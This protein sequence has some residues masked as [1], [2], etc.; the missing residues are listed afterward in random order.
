MNGF[1]SRQR[2]FRAN[3]PFR[4]DYRGNFSI[5]GLALW[6]RHRRYFRCH[7]FRSAGFSSHNIPRR[8]CCKRGPVRS[9]VRR[10]R[11]RAADR[12][13]RAAFNAFAGCGAFH[14]R[15]DRNGFG[16]DNAV[17]FDGAACCGDC[18]RHCS[19]HGPPLHIGDFTTSRAWEVS[20]AQPIDDHDWNRLLLPGGLWPSRFARLE[21][22]VRVAAIRR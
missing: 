8:N 22:D 9:D 21:M 11:R 2:F 16:A 17:A 5:I 6:L 15:S 14:P 13:A 1:E 20:V 10:S 3:R 19:V 12:P 18:N 7:S 4:H